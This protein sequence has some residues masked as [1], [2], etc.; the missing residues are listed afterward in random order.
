MST[1]NA[2]K[3]LETT[4]REAAQ[5]LDASSDP[6]EAA[7]LLV[8]AAIGLMEASSGCLVQVDSTS[9]APK[10][11]AARNVTHKIVDDERIAVMLATARE[12]IQSNT[13]SLGNGALCVPT[14]IY[15]RVIGALYVGRTEPFAPADL[16]LLTAFAAQAT[17]ILENMQLQADIRA[18]EVARAKF[19]SHVAHELRLPMTSIKGYADLMRSG[20]VGELNDQQ[21]EFIDVITSNVARMRSLV[22]NLSDISHMDSNRMKIETGEVALQTCIAAAVSGLKLDI[23]NRKQTLTLELPDDLPQLHTDQSRVAQILTNLVTNAHMYTPEGGEITIRAT[24]DGDQVCIEVID[25]GIGIREADKPQIF[26]QFFRSEVQEVREHQGWGLGLY[27]SK[28]LA[29]VLGGEMSFTSE[30]GQGTTFA[31]SIPAA[32]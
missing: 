31:F 19:V 14:Q 15:G 32:R 16:D 6:S 18:A 30:P 4:L 29:E 12:V 9:G 22:S 27:V 17:L 21:L 24:P 11:V 10:V 1:T 8:D 23:E 5:A 28:R 13:A 25:T 26:T 2:L 3:R 7:A 20:M